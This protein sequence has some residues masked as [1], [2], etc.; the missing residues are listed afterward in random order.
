MKS[1]ILGI[2]IA[3][4]LCAGYEVRVY[5]Q[6][7]TED[8]KPSFIINEQGKHG[9]ITFQVIVTD[10]GAIDSITVLES[11]EIRGAGI[12][13]K[14]FLK[15]FIGKTLKDPLTL[16]KDIDALTGAT[17]SSDA[18]VRAAKKALIKWKEGKSLT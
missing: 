10:E 11:K 3:I 2:A 5:T 14:R 1:Y 6:E 7:K 15:Q 16:G 18:A 9:P 13:K 8:G 17:V 12:S 4:Y